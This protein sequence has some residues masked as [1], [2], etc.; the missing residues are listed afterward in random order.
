MQV[1]RDHRISPY[2]PFRLSDMDIQTLPPLRTLSYGDFGLTL[3]EA[4]EH[5]WQVLWAGEQIATQRTSMTHFEREGV[6]WQGTGVKLNTGNHK[7][8]KGCLTVTA[9]DI[10]WVSR[11]LPAIDSGV[12]ET[13]GVLRLWLYVSDAS[14]L[15]RE[16]PIEL[17]SSG[18]YDRDEFSWNLRGLSLK[19]GWNDLALQ[20]RI[21]HKQGKPDPH[22][23]R[24]FRVYS[25]LSGS[26]T[27]K[28]DHVRV[29]R[30]RNETKEE[31]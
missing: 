9:D 1:C 6:G 27:L 13:T 8:G 5:P 17:T 24:F 18:T 22:N 21:A 26:V 31:Q 10:V 19:N 2:H 23:I 30:L 11:R 15:V 20:F 16:S 12:D 14:R 7:Q 29:E 3:P 28:L 25:F 4:G